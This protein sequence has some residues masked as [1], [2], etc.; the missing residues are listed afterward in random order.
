MNGFLFFSG[1]ILRWT[2]Q[3]PKEFLALSAYF[4]SLHG[5]TTLGITN[6]FEAIRL[7]FTMGTLAPLLLAIRKGLPLDCLNYKASLMRE[8]ETRQVP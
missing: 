7:L 4:F 3:K 8:I 6:S 1:T 2:V 5:V